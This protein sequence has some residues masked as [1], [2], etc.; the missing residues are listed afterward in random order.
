[1]S[2]QLILHAPSVHTG[3]GLVLLQSLLSA[4]P[5]GRSLIGFFDARARAVLPLPS[6][7]HAIW[8]SPTVAA[9]I[10]A[11]R[12]L[13]HV[14]QPGDTVLCFHGL[15]PIC[16][17]A[18]RVLVFAQNRIHL[19]LIP[20]TRYPLRVALR[21]AL[22][23]RFAHLRRNLVAEYIVQTSTMARELQRWHGGNPIVRVLP[24]ADPVAA[25]APAGP[26]RWDFV[27]VAD[28]GA[29]KNHRV[30][31][32]AWALLAGQGCRPSLALTLGGN[33][34]ALQA[35]VEALRTR[36]GAE[37]HNSGAGSHG[38]VLALL[39]GAR[40][41]IYPSLGE[42]FGLPLLE[43]AQLGLP[44]VAAERDYVRDVCDPAQTFDPESPVSIARA[45]RRFLAR[46][47]P[48][49]TVPTAAAWWA[50]LGFGAP[51]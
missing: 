20:L 15:P 36:T 38:Q 51:R 42:S 25:L 32:D 3:G 19:G 13:R 12:R 28:G 48:P 50:A 39:A 37:V 46:P 16:Q 17:S 7:A 31:L 8:V 18:G 24:F 29:H 23:R 6:S 41:L 21:L 33:D 40:A 34:S 44:I 27:Y 49:Q 9:R 30:L 43:A 10:A 4:W 35:E 47:E 11:E 2:G 1:M 5:S 45:V 22:E 14:A 26:R